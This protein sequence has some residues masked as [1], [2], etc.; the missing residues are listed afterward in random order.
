MSEIVKVYIHN[1]PTIVMVQPLDFKPGKPDTWYYDQAIKVVNL[2]G[3][4]WTHYSIEYP[5]GA[6]QG[7]LYDIV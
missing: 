1:G 4:E 6:K 2:E 3:I 5:S 7:T